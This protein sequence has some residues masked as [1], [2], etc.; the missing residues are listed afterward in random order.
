VIKV[1]L[2]PGDG[3][4]SE[5]VT[6]AHRVLEAVSAAGAA[7]LSFEYL[8]HGADH[9]LS[10]GETLGD[11][12][13]ARLRDDFD[14]IL[15]G[16]LGDPRVPDDRHARDILLGLRFRLDLFTNFRP[17]RLRA[18]DLSPLATGGDEETDLVIFRENTE[19]FY[20]GSG[21]ILRAGTPQEVAVSESFAT[22]FGVER[23][24]R[25]AFDFATADGRTLVTLADK[26]NAVP[27]VYGLWRRAFFEIAAEYAGVEAEARYADALAME[28][29]RSPAR[30]QVIV[31]ENLLADIL[32]DL[33][34]E[35]IGGLG[36]APS[37]NLHPGR[38]GLYE[39]VHGSAPELAGQGIANPMATVLSAALLLRDLGAP[40]AADAVEAAV[41]AALASGIRT[42]D[43]GGSSTCREVGEWLAE[44]VESTLS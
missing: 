37:A 42:P 14:A 28:L 3:I 6:E 2:I 30:F 36:L 15:L 11:E 27:H 1:A 20:T 10:T 40:A 41:D 5:V 22:R 23:I 4:G 19:G 24:V 38:T 18:P 16:A 12:T 35:L 17:L 29:V 31:A 9:F 34:A 13:F 32:S 21:G 33:G 44:A 8:P 26:S 25:A 43:I 7:S 39:P